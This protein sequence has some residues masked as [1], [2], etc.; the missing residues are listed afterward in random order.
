MEKQGVMLGVSIWTQ[1]SKSG[2]K[3]TAKTQREAVTPF[4]SLFIKH[5]F[6]FLVYECFA[7]MYACVPRGVKY[8]QR[9]EQ[10]VGSPGAGVT[11]CCELPC[12]R[13]E[14]NPDPLKEQPTLLTTE[15]L[16]IP[17]PLFL[18]RSW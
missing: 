14:S 1:G 2:P 17:S 5:L 4:L 10:G 8:S 6:L 18:E 11:D 9:P 13:W 12:G 16:L 15:S 3:T 7:N